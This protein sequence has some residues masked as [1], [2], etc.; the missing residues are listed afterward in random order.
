MSCIMRAKLIALV[1]F[2]VRKKTFLALY[3]K[4]SHLFLIT[5]ANWFRISKLLPFAVKLS[6]N[7]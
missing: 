6:K 5:N 1:H 7:G 2:S 3:S 4:V